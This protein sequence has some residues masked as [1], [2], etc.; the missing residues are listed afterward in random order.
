[1]STF[2][3]KYNFTVFFSE[4]ITRQIKWNLNFMSIYK[5]PYRLSSI[6]LASFSIGLT[7]IKLITPCFSMCLC[8]LEGRANDASQCEHE[9]AFSVSCLS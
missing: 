1:M 4:L 7:L 8:N 5:E 9:Y 6:L 3:L 2:I